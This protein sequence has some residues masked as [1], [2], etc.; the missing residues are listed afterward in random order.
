MFDIMRGDLVVA[1]MEIAAICERVGRIKEWQ[2]NFDGPF[3][4]LSGTIN[5]ISTDVEIIMRRQG[6][7]EDMLMEVHSL[8]ACFEAHNINNDV[9]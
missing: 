9:I 8:M 2:H 7:S 6:R 5:Q 3:D 1:R 4:S